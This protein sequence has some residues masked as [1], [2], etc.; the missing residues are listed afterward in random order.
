MRD[1]VEIVIPQYYREGFFSKDSL[2]HPELQGGQYGVMGDPVPY[3]VRADDILTV[4]MLSCFVMVVIAYSH[5]RGFFSRHAKN[6]F[7]LPHEGTTEVTET[8]TEVRFQ[9]FIV[10]LTSLLFAMLYYFY[11][12]RTVGETFVLSS[13]Y[14][15]ILIFLGIFLVYYLL[16]VGAYSLVNKVFFGGKKNRQWVKSLLFLTAV[17][18]LLTIP[19]VVMGPYF[20][21][22]VKTI[23]LYV[24]FV[25]IFVKLLT[26]YKCFIIFFRQNVVSL[27]IILYLCALE[28]VPLLALWG[29]L[30]M[31]ANSLKINF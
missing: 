1:D 8:A 28:I 14:Y 7:Y 3:S 30:G 22:P 27:Q 21:L 16:R 2:L 4:L 26:F 6:F 25:L 12:L 9:V 11:T 29:V 24:V 18:G 10:F 13:Q 19:A 31:T 23:A 5:V 20:D 17:E 15:L